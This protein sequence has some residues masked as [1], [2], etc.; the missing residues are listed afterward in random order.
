[1]IEEYELEPM[2]WRLTYQLPDCEDG[3]TTGGDVNISTVELLISRMI[4]W[5]EGSDS[6]AIVERLDKRTAP[7]DAECMCDR[8]LVTESG[9]RFS[10]SLDDQA[11][12]ADKD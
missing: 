7:T 6:D 9:G 8:F 10:A 12:L 4:D 2:V 11:L 5:L 1:M 3:S